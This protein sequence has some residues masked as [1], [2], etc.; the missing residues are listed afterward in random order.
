MLE[1]DFMVNAFAASG[2]V[3]VL[4]GI[5][6]YFLVLRGQTFAGHALAHVGFTGATGAALLGLHPLGGMIAFTLAA[7][8]GMGALGERIAGRDV[9][10][11]VVLSLALGA[12]L[13]FSR[14]FST[15]TTQITSLLFGNV[16]GVDRHTLAALAVLAVLSLAALTLFGRRLIFTSLQP[17]LAEAKGVSLR[18]TSM[19]FLAV[20]A[21]AV[22]ASTQIVGVLLVFTLM[23]APAAAAQ[24][25]AVGLAR[26]V[27]LA[28]VLSLAEAWSGIALAYYTDWPTSFWITAVG[29]VIYLLSA[30]RGRLR[31]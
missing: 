3:A 7:G 9:A 25:L 5:V 22:A 27:A 8:V 26:G 30:A 31:R 14:F 24:N 17:E 12:G 13:L 16:L 1:Y 6:G 2:I 19:L 29:G 28:A 4:A 21:V 11:G 18:A 15:S 20:V 10:I 23:V